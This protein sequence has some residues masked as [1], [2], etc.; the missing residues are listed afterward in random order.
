M[1]SQEEN[2]NFTTAQ[3]SEN[4]C[5]NTHIRGWIVFYL[6]HYK[7]LNY[8]LFFAIGNS[9]SGLNNG[10]NHLCLL[11]LGWRTTNLTRRDLF[12][13]TVCLGGLSKPL[14]LHQWLSPVGSKRIVRQL[15]INSTYK[16]GDCTL[17]INCG[18]FPSFHWF[19]GRSA[20]IYGAI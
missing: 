9:F 17:S 3:V 19:S 12:R 11:N 14:H 20:S 5:W 2:G 15:N 4:S 10:A 16:I 8:Y 6:V 7:M 18:W 13:L 1:P